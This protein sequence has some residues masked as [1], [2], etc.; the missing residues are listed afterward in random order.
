MA[1]KTK[2]DES[3]TA[4]NGAIV[5][6][7]GSTAR[8][9][10]IH[11]LFGGCLDFGTNMKLTG[12]DRYQRVGKC[13]AFSW[14]GLGC[15]DAYRLGAVSYDE[16]DDGFTF[17]RT[18]SKKAKIARR[19]PEA[20]S[21]EPSAILSDRRRASIPEKKVRGE[22]STKR[23]NVVTSSKAPDEA[24]SKRKDAATQRRAPDEVHARRKNAVTESE[25][26]DEDSA[27]SRRRSARVAGA[28]SYG[29]KDGKDYDEA[30]EKTK[31]DAEP[32]GHPEL[33]MS[34]KDTT[35]IALPF[36]DTPVIKRNKAFREIGSKGHRRSSTGLRGRRASSLI[37]HGSDGEHARDSNCG[38]N[39]RD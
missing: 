31:E 32:A 37:D 18:R 19:V 39:L 20:V 11:V 2:T 15:R 38:G 28:V 1:K 14:R 10:C 35:T 16:E 13:A 29:Q 22:A 12:L 33:S 36:S 17:T 6:D 26:A 30:I 7:G 21:E 4:S 9:V 3:H 27:G 23:K 24:S 34:S 5:G 8:K 25:A